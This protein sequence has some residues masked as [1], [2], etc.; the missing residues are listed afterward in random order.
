MRRRRKEC[1]ANL[2]NEENKKECRVVELT[3]VDQEVAKISK[4]DVKKATT[5]ELS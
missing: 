1:F 4:D 5:E 3:I 2:M